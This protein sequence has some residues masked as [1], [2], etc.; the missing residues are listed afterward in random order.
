VSEPHPDS[1]RGDPLT[2]KEEA[3]IEEAMS[4]REP[5]VQLLTM[6]ESAIRAFIF[7]LLPHWADA[8]EVLQESESL[9]SSLPT[10]TS[11]AGLA[12]LPSFKFASSEEKNTVI[13]SNLASQPSNKLRRFKSRKAICSIHAVKHWPIVSSDWTTVTD[14]CLPRDMSAIP[15]SKK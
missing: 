11:F 2:A 8:E 15:R 5:F 3:V 1:P 12:G 14:R 7:S 9:T 4:S 13:D 6:H 10:P